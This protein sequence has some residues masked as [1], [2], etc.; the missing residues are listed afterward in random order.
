[1][2]TGRCYGAKMLRFG[3][4]VRKWVVDLEIE[5]SFRNGRYRRFRLSNL[6]FNFQTPQ[7]PD[8]QVESESAATLSLDSIR[9][10]LI[11]RP[12]RRV[13]SAENLP[14]SG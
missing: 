14:W 10:I 2:G 1:M 11:L 7:I 12:I 13:I 3:P 8:F 4:R 6:T 5:M 9:G